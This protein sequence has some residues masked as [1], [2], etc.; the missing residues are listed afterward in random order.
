M[1]RREQ[2]SLVVHVGHSG[3]GR[4]I[5][6]PYLTPYILRQ[7]RRVAPRSI[8]QLSGRRCGVRLACDRERMG[9]GH[10]LVPQCRRARRDRRQSEAGAEAGPLV[11]QMGH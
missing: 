9:M 8:L 11:V 3:V 2:F 7:T 5:T 1:E 4:Q 10:A 6:L